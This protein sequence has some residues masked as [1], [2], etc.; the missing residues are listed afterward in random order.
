MRQEKI[1]EAYCTRTVGRDSLSCSRQAALL[2]HIQH[3]SRKVCGAVTPV[4]CLPGKWEEGAAIAFLRQFRF[5]GF[6]KTFPIPG[7]LICWEKE[8]CVFAF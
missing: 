6:E 8:D 1:H 2:E 7:E 3:I 4:F 5:S